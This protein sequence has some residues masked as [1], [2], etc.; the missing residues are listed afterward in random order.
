M[1]HDRVADSLELLAE[2]FLLRHQKLP[3]IAAQ[4]H[5]TAAA[6]SPNCPSINPASVN[7]LHQHRQIHR[8]RLSNFHRVSI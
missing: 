7:Q 8:H 5:P 1:C 3:H 4:Q 2:F 6:D